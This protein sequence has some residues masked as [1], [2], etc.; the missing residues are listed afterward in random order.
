MLFL[1]IEE[2]GNVK[3]QVQDPSGGGK[4]WPGL[5]ILSSTSV[6]MRA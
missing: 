6:W 4:N 5:D 1:Y 2:I 3:T